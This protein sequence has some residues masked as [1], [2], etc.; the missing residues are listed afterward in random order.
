MRGKLTCDK[1]KDAFALL[2][3]SGNPLLQTS[4]EEHD[5]GDEDICRSPMIA[6]WVGSRKFVSL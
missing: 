6:L 2:Q 4:R 1:A 3:C 5:D